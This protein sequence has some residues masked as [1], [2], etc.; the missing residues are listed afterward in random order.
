MND[1]PLRWRRYGVAQHRPISLGLFAQ[2]R[3]DVACDTQGRIETCHNVELRPL[4]IPE[5]GVWTR[6]I[7]PAYD[8]ND[9]T[10]PHMGLLLGRDWSSVGIF[11]RTAANV[12]AL[13]CV[14]SAAKRR[15]SGATENCC[16]DRYVWKVLGRLGSHGHWGYEI[17]ATRRASAAPINCLRARGIGMKAAQ[18]MCAEALA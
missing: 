4:S 16:G 2:D 13:T 9:G 1:V 12:D 6:P 17:H 5:H 15:R 3:A 14:H 11:R 8:F 7:P 10:I 18:R